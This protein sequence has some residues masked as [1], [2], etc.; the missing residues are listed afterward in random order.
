MKFALVTDLYNKKK[1][2]II[3]KYKSGNIYYNQQIEGKTIY[4]FTRTTKKF[5][6]L[7]FKTN[8][9]A[10]VVVNNF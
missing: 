4:C 5:L 10:L 7:M 1:V 9:K 3:K 8:E 2:W 6:K